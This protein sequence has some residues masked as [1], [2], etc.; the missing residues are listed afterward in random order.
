MV[1]VWVRTIR[2]VDL[3]QKKLWEGELSHIPRVGD[4]IKIKPEYF[5]LRVADVV[6]QLYDSVVVVIVEDRI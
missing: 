4:G 5:L 1:E 3:S 6:Y 2:G